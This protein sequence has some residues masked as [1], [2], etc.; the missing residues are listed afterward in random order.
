M[1]P[2]VHL[3]LNIFVNVKLTLLCTVDS[4]YVECGG[5]SQLTTT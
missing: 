4:R 1:V 2:I 5:T 3:F